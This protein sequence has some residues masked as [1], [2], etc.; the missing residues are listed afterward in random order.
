[1]LR[2]LAALIHPDLSRNIVLI[3]GPRHCGK[4]SLAKNLGLSTQHLD[5]EDCEHRVTIRDRSWDRKKEL[6]V[7]DELHKKPEWKQYLK[8]LYDLEGIPPAILVTGSASLEI[9]RKLDDSLTGSFSGR[10]FLYRLHPFDVRELSSQ[11]EPQEALERI[12]RVGGFPEPFLE[13]DGSMYSRW[14]KSHMDIILRQ[15]LLDLVTVSDLHSM[16]LLLDLLRERVGSPLSIAALARDLRKD[17]KTVKRWLGILE[18]LYVVFPVRPWHRNL[19]RSLLKEPKYYFYDTGQVADSPGPRLE[20]AVACSLLKALHYFEDRDGSER[21]L[22]Y[23]RTRDGREIDFAIVKRDMVSHLIEVGISG[24][25]LSPGFAQLGPSFPD[26]KRIQLVLAPA[27]KKTW[28]TG[29]ELH[30]AAEWLAGL[31]V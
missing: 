27:R 5:Y 7:L 24:E 8:G 31:I 12:L 16:E 9:H 1:M 2:D 10:F 25:K 18:N 17:A 3:T 6:I 4:T 14:K 13:N 22:H 15:D 29:E 23:L 19:A 30:Q 26:A 20:N 28:S 11:M 21:S